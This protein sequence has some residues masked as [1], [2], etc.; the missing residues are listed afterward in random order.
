MGLDSVEM[1]LAVEDAFRIDI[2]DE[3]A[4]DMFT[5]QD[6]IDY[7]VEHV[8]MIPQEKCQTQR[9]FCKL[10]GAFRKK[11]PALEGDF[12]LQTKLKKVI[13]K[14]QWLEIWASITNE[15]GEDFWP[16]TIQWP[17]FMLKRGPSTIRE[18]V[19]HI[20]FHLPKP[21]VKLNEPWT[22]ERVALKVREIIGDVLG[23]IDFH[24][25]ADFAKD[26]RLT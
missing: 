15:V 9:I 18:L 1:V 3:I 25:S 12:R 26:L 19:Y 16:E 6:L 13:H 23:I 2:P 17:S 11:I 20:A 24:Q 7:L 22:R 5:V 10:R 14:A 4:T 21:D 8:P